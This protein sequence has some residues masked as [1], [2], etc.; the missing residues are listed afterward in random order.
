QLD[1]AGIETRPLWKPMHLQPLYR[2]A[3]YYRGAEAVSENLFRAGLCLPSG[4]RVSKED[5]L[6]RIFS[7][8]CVGK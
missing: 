7:K 1:L 5:V 4:P 2:N 6:N 8:F 3:L